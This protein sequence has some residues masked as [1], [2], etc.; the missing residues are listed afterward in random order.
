VSRHARAAS[1]R[2]AAPPERRSADDVRRA[3]HGRRRARHTHGADRFWLGPSAHR[4]RADRFVRQAGAQRHGHLGA[5]W[6]RV[7]AEGARV[8]PCDHPIGTPDRVLRV[9]HEPDH[10]LGRA[11]ALGSCCGGQGAGLRVHETHRRAANRRRGAGVGRSCRR[12]GTGG[13]H[14]RLAIRGRKDPRRRFRTAPGL[15]LC[16]RRRLAVRRRFVAASWTIAG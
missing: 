14:R 11:V 13:H 16:D 4:V 9:R 10:A 1:A 12:A 5:Q 8:H 6:C 15:D 2:T 7:R 3:C